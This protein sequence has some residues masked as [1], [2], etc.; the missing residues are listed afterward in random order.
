MIVFLMIPHHPRSR[1]PNPLFPY[2]T[3]FRS[4]EVPRRALRAEDRVRR[5]SQARLWRAR[6]VARDADG[7]CRGLSQGVDRCRRLCAQMGQMGKGRWRRRSEIGRENVRTPVTN[8]HLVCRLLL[9]KK[10]R[11]KK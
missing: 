4:Y 9:E 11:K 8:A 2:T 6:T 5:E 7:Q 1:R 10:K 3:L